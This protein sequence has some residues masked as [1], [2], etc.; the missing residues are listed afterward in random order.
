MIPGEVEMTRP[1]RP[2]SPVLR[3]PMHPAPAQKVP[4]TSPVISS[5]SRRLTASSEIELQTQ[6][7]MPQT[8]KSTPG[9]VPAERGVGVQTCSHKADGHEGVPQFYLQLGGPRALLNHDFRRML[10]RLPRNSRGP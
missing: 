10:Q 7:S 9:N 4:E 6:K 2:N 3:F 5:G 8:Q 1:Y